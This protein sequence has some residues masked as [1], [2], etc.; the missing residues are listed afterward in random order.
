LPCPSIWLRRP[1][2]QFRLEVREGLV[3][4]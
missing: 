2:R 1:F 4:G 3:E